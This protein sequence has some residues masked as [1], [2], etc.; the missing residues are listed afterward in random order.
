MV[1]YPG[2]LSHAALIL[3]VNFPD[4]E[5]VENFH[6]SSLPAPTDGLI[7]PHMIYCWALILPLFHFTSEALES[8][9]SSSFKIN[10]KAF[11]A[12]LR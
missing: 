4:L 12:V 7:S 11:R 10:P 9:C 1:R 8:G 2:F 6:A 5:V 3:M